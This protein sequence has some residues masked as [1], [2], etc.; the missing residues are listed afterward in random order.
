M[1]EHFSRSAF[2]V[3]LGHGTECFAV[4]INSDTTQP[5]RGMRVASSRTRLIK[6]FSLLS[7]TEIILSVSDRCNRKRYS[8]SCYLSIVA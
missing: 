8:I 1:R 6:K 5:I 4:T 3:S 7:P 2:R